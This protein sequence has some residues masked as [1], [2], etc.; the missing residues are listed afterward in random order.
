M[1]ASKLFKLIS[2]R[3]LKYMLI[4]GHK[5]IFSPISVILLVIISI[6]RWYQKI[7]ASISLNLLTESEFFWPRALR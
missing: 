7:F 4:D 1:H 3:C 6:K 2:G 5:D